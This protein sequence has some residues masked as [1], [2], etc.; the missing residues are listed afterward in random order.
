MRELSFRVGSMATAGSAIDGPS[1]LRVAYLRIGV[2]CMKTKIGLVVGVFATAM[3]MTFGVA[4]T[5][6]A[7]AGTTFCGYQEAGGTATWT[8]SYVGNRQCPATDI[9]NGVEGNLVWEDYIA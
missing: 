7:G 9:K 2:N 1:S 5:A 3:A 6:S 8:K 4:G